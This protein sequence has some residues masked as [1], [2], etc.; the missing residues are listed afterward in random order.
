MQELQI[1]GFDVRQVTDWG[2]A[3]VLE[4]DVVPA[5][6]RPG[7]FTSKGKYVKPSSYPAFAVVR[8]QEF[9]MTCRAFARV[10]GFCAA[11]YCDDTVITF[12]LNDRTGRVRESRRVPAK[13]NWW[14]PGSQP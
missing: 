11:V 13:I 9:R 8:H 6:V 14:E 3:V 2:R 5:G 10:Y 12:A 7:Y 4:H 1:N